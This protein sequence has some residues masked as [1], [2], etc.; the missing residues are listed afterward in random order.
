MLTAYKAE[1]MRSLGGVFIGRFTNNPENPV[2]RL[3]R[4][5]VIEDEKIA[6]ADF[7]AGQWEPPEPE[8]LE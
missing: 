6:E 3:S 4:Y 2:E 1:I 5:Y 8:G 7:E